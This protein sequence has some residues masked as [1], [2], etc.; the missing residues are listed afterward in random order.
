MRLARRRTSS[1]GLSARHRH[2]CT[3][4]PMPRQTGGEAMVEEVGNMSRLAIA[5]V[6]GALFAACS[7]GPNDS[8]FV[9]ACMNEG[10]GLASRDARQGIGR[11]ERCVLRMR[12]RGREVVAI[13]GRVPGNDSRYAGQEG[14]SPK[15]HFQDE[16]LRA[17][18][19]DD[20][21][22]RNAGKV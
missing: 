6:V 20:G 14:G 13:V 17:A 5:I 2:I 19:R 12:G 11:H 22:R 9:A 3:A 21:S 4:V 10:Q 8:E 7:G 16:R 1:T 18:G 15:H